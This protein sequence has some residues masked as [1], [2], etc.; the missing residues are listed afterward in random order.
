MSGSSR[1][2]REAAVL[3]QKSV[4]HERFLVNIEIDSTV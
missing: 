4:A 3:Q 1:D 2:A